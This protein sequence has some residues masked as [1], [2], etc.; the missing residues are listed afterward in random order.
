MDQEELRLQQETNERLGE[1]A[2]AQRK[3]AAAQD[4]VA[5]AQEEHNRKSEWDYRKHALDLAIGMHH[6]RGGNMTVEEIL[7]AAERFHTYLLMGPG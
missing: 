2:D 6:H 5:A 7:S 4:R 3:M 1:A